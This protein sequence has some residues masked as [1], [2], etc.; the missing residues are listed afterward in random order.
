MNEDD[1][2]RVLYAHSH[3]TWV[4]RFIGAIRYTMAHPV[5]SFLDELFRRENPGRICVD[6]ND[7]T[8][9]DSTGIGLLAKIAVGLEQAG[10]G[11]PLLFSSN[12]DIIETLRNVCLDEVCTLLPGAPEAVAANAIPDTCPDERQLARTIVSVHCLLCDLSSENRAKFKGVIDAFE[13][14]LAAEDNP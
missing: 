3:G 12:P 11:A 5:D 4:L 9:I 13:N 14:D 2:G 1:Q 8:S 6:L 7:T 10:K